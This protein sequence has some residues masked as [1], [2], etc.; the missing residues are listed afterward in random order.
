MPLKGGIVALCPYYGHLPGFRRLTIIV[1]TV[2][3]RSHLTVLR[4]SSTRI[5]SYCSC[6]LEWWDVRTP[7]AILNVFDFLDYT[8]WRASE[9]SETFSGLFNR[10]SRYMFILEKWFP[11]QGERAHSLLLFL[12]MLIERRRRKTEQQ[13]QFTNGCNILH[14][15]QVYHLT[16]TF[17]I[18]NKYTSTLYL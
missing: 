2:S 3:K 1:C 14:R 17:I 9:L 7:G 11:F 4:L 13:Q 5:V 15:L 12:Y 18:H 16:L 8:Y 10:E 6:A